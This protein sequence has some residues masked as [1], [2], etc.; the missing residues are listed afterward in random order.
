M[1]VLHLRTKMKSIA[2]LVISTLIS[3]NFALICKVCE[4]SEE[5]K[6]GLCKNLVN[7]ECERENGTPGE[8]VTVQMFANN[9]ML[10]RLKI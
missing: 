10:N 2:L 6:M 7:Q 3:R 9:S 8:C 1:L 5:S 4:D